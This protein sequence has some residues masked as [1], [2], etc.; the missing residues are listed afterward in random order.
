MIIFPHNGFIAISPRSG[1]LMFNRWVQENFFKYMLYFFNIDGLIEYGTIPF[2]EPCKLV[3]PAWKKLDYAIN[4]IRQKLRYRM[5]KFTQ[6]ELFADDGNS[7]KT[8]QKKADLCGE[9]E[10]F[11]AEMEDLQKQRKKYDKH[12][13]FE[14]LPDELKFERLKPTKRLFY[15]T[16]KM[17]VYRAETAMANNVKPLLERNDDS[18]ALI[19][20]LSK[21]HADIHPDKNN[22]ILNVKVHRFTTKRHDHAIKNFLQLLN[23]TE[24]LYPGTNMQLRYSLVGKNDNIST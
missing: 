6:I 5:A 15:D 7:K 21:S 24:T 23:D 1:S 8:I 10:Q 20:Q 13:S 14:E 17:L 4:S 19:R 18:K 22:N 11:Q 3:N 9:I 2:S 12:V 16:I